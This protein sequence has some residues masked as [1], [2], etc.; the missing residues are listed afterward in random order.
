MRRIALILMLALAG[1]TG[2]SPIRIRALRT[3]VS[4]SNSRPVKP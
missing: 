1:L 4:A 3:T 2:Y